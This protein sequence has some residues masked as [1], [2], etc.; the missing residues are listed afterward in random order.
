M[1]KDNGKRKIFRRERRVKQANDLALNVFLRM[2]MQPLRERL[3]L[4]RFLVF[5]SDLRYLARKHG[6]SVRQVME[7]IEQEEKG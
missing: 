5:Q 3:K 2:Q 7:K 4:A 1:S 6:K